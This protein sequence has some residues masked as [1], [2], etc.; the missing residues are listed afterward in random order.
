MA[1]WRRLWQ[2]YVHEV[3]DN[4]VVAAV[5][6]LGGGAALTVALWFRF[7]EHESERERE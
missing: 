4:A 7:S 1:R 3:L 6:E 2:S 5:S